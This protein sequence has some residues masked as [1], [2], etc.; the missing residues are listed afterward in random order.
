MSKN[1][2]IPQNTPYCYT[3][4]GRDVNTGRLITTTCP[5]LTEKNGHTYCLKTKIISPKYDVNLLWDW[6]KVCGISDT[7]EMEDVE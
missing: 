1:G 3:I 7:F 5:Y 6:I 4:N 2:G